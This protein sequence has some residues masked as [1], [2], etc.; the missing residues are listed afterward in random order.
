MKFSLLSLIFQFQYFFLL[1]YTDGGGG[2]D[3]TPADFDILEGACARDAD[4]VD[5][6]GEDF[7]EGPPTVYPPI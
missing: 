3:D 1:Y 4:A 2:D 5:V 7:F 6:D